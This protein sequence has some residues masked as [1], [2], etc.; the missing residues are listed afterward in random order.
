[1]MP[2]E[3]IKRLDG[4]QAMVRLGQLPSAMLET[5]PELMMR[6]FQDPGVKYI[7]G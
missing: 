6:Y 5:S 4:R 7:A 2:Q 3:L 1:M